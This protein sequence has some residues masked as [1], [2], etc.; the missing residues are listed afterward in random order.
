MNISVQ[1]FVM[2]AASS[3]LAAGAVLLPA[4]AMAETSQPAPQAAAGF[5]HNASDSC[6]AEYANG[7]RQGYREGYDFG[8]QQG[9][10]DGYKRGY[11]DGYDKAFRP[12]HYAFQQP[13]ECTEHFERGYSSGF[14]KGA[15]KGY[16]VGY[17]KGYREGKHQ[18]HRDGR[19]DS[20]H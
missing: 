14:E 6:N 20:R 7:Y 16:H 13:G 18:G 11:A 10:D 12:K 19:E 5:A 17:D 9:Y 1:R 8:H 2:A 15:E 4:T 3:A